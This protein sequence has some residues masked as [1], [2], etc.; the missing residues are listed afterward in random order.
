M[1]GLLFTYALTYGGA[2][3]ALFNP[4]IGLL[5][6]VCFA[7]LRPESLWF[8]SVPAGNYSRIV[9]I[10]LLIGWAVNG[11][12]NWQLGRARGVVMALLGYLAWSCLSAAFARYPEH[13]WQFVENTLKVVL[14]FLVG[15]TTLDSM[16]KLKQLAWVILLSQGYVAFELNSAYYS[17]FNRMHEVGFGGMD[18]NCVAIA[19]VAATGLAFFLG[20]AEPQWWKKG[21]A[22]I[23]S[24][25]MVHC[26]MF[27][28]SR[29]GMLGL[30]I[31]GAVA[32]VLIPKQPKHYAMF[33]IAILIAL[34]LAGPQ[35][36]TRFASTFADGE[37]RDSSA[38]SRLDMWEDCADVVVK[39]PL[40]GIGPDNWPLIAH[41]YGWP[42]GK[43]A[44][45][46]WVQMAA[47]LGLVGV[48]FLA[49]F[50]ARCL[51]GL[52]TLVK[53]PSAGRR[54]R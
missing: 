25:L 30:L 35:V 39:H 14:P 16:A 40:L 8:W 37:E 32:F 9:A 11:F 20:M 6:Y 31:T 26:V 23:A 13:G 29:G 43:E 18:N 2:A 28:F 27:G 50:Y 15:V 19:M 48:G 3:V 47:E 22:L 54:Y 24:V 41:E 34:R 51:T 45:S 17:G 33:A 44:H 10:A 53:N 21:I 4:W 46:L 49:L 5:V 7:I 36:V 38:Q 52:R 42:P 12:G 1:K